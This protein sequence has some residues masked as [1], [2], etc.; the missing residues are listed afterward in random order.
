MRGRCLMFV[1]LVLVGVPLVTGGDAQAAPEGASI[2]VRT[3]GCAAFVD[4]ASAEPGRF[5]ALVGWLDGWV[6]AE[7]VSTAYSLEAQA[8]QGKRW[9]ERCRAEPAKPL[10]DVLKTEK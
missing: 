10:F 2:D 5:R 7:K 3:L 6:N 9:L 4:M 8:G 1:A